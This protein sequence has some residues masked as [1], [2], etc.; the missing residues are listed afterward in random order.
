EHFPI[1]HEK[2]AD[3]LTKDWCYLLS[4]DGARAPLRLSPVVFSVPCATCKRV[5]TY[6]SDGL[7]FGPRG[8]KARGRGV[9]TN[10]EET[11]EVP[12][13]KRNQGF[14][15]LLEKEGVAQ[16]EDGDGVTRVTNAYAAILNDATTRDASNMT[17]VSPATAAKA[18]PAA[19]P[20]PP[21][22]AIAPPTK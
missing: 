2:I 20:V 18:A 1:I 11:V 14:Q 7:V 22:P 12:W 17:P 4:D 21:G 13:Q 16:W 3:R 6:L 19:R 15:E 8:A 10:H 5:E 9:T